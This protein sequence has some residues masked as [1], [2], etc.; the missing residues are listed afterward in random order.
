MNTQPQKNKFY[1]EPFPP[2]WASEWGEDIHG[3][4]ATFIYQNVQ[5]TFRWIPAGKFMMGS[6]EGEEGR[7]S[8]EDLH[9]VVLTHGFWLADTTVTQAFWL[10]IMNDNPSRFSD[11]MNK[12]VENI[13]WDDVKL[14][15]VRLNGVHSRLNARFPTEAE[16]EYACRAG[17]TGAFNFTGEL[18]L[19]KV[20]YRGLWEWTTADEWGEGARKTTVAVKSMQTP[21]QWGL[22]EM[23]GNVWEWCQDVWQEHI[24]NKKV[25]NPVI[26]EGGVSRVVRGG[27][28][29]LHGGGVRSAIRLLSSPADRDDSVGFRLALGHASQVRQVEQSSYQT[30]QP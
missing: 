16:W 27:S 14:F 26:T 25:E 24:G 17:I 5:Q 21:N 7:F 2:V 30:G 20:N 28:W 4:W 9:P 1:P 6:P 13:S 8:D 22:H 15:I 29:R 3:L 10:A 11:D 12:P 19:D 18:S 23:H